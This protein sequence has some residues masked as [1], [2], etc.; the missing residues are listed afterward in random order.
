VCMYVLV[1]TLVSMFMCVY[2]YIQQTKQAGSSSYASG[3]YS[4]S[5]QF[6]PQSRQIKLTMGFVVFLSFL[7][8]NVKQH[9]KLGHHCFL[10]HHFPFIIH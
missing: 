5:E 4:V 2:I 10:Q 7:L 1:C 8:A 9:L 3:L 6:K